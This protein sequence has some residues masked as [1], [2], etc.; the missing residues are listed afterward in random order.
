M[1]ETEADK[2]PSTEGNAADQMEPKPEIKSEAI[3]TGNQEMPELVIDPEFK[4]LIPPLG[5]GELEALEKSLNEEGCRDSL[6]TCKLDGIITLL[7]GHHRLEICKKLGTLFRTIEIKVSSRNEAKIWIIKNQRGRRNLN[8][9]Q[10]AMLAVTLE[11]LYSEQ[12]KEN[13]GTRTDRGQNLAHSEGRSAEKAGEDMGVSHQTVSFAKKVVKECI[14]EVAKFIESGDIAVS[15]AAKVASLGKEDQ[16]KVT[17]M[18][19]TSIKEGEKPNVAA[20]IHDVTKTPPEESD[21]DKR[22]GKLGDSLDDNLKLLESIEQIKQPENIVGILATTQKIV[23]KLKQIETKSLEPGQDPALGCVIEVKQ[24]KAL[25]DS[26]M[27]VNNQ[28]RLKSDSNGMSVVTSDMLG[29]KTVDAFL[30]KESFAKYEEL[31]E[32]GLEAAVTQKFLVGF[33]KHM[34]M[35]VDSQDN[36]LHMTFGAREV[37]QQLLLPESISDYPRLPDPTPAC[38]MTVPGKEF[39][40]ALECA[41]DFMKPKQKKRGSKYVVPDV[42]FVISDNALAL[43]CKTLEN[44]RMKVTCPCEVIEQTGQVHSRFNIDELISIKQTI[45]R[46]ENVT[47]GLGMIQPMIL[48]LTIEKMRVRYIVDTLDAT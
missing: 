19:K 48:D 5:R 41:K 37:K 16:M 35:F 24:F 17:E 11:A 8:E 28:I 10:R 43:V 39:V 30:P 31:G 40:H 15:A 32:I 14:P 27:P 9:S 23:E 33:K 2:I 4:L 34:R 18:I 22:L 21:A 45:S 46:S 12:A 47:L 25:L 6:V 42:R 20:I 13:M 1:T 38:I 29:K 3:S 26:I 36:K 7:D 44:D